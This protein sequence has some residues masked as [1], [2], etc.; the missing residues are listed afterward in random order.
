MR[1]LIEQLQEFETA[2]IA[3]SMGAMGCPDPERYY[4]GSDIKL[5]TNTGGLVA[6]VAFT[7]E[8]DTSTPGITPEMEDYWD[9]VERITQSK[10][11]VLVVMKAVG[12]RPGHECLCGDGMCKI[13]LASG[14]VGIV[15]DGPVRDVQGINRI[16]FA[17]FATGTVTNHGNMVYR[18]STGPIDLSGIS[19]SQG[20]LLA[21]DRD[22]IVKIP[23][24][25][26]AGIVEAC[27]ISRDFETRAH[28][29]WRRS[30]KTPKE[31]REYVTGLALERDEKCRHLL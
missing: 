24:R 1:A 2:L 25:Y 23:K 6:G 16:G 14:S 12:S 11:P 8:A 26:H 18:W 3:E 22:G 29:F 5:L 13:L 9:C 30:D 4:T 17:I 19:V 21:G 7:L 31:K 27:I 28:T 20:D 15:A 10:E